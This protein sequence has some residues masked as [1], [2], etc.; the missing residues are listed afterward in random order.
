MKITIYKTIS[1]LGLLSFFVISCTEVIDI[2]LNSTNPEMNELLGYTLN[3]AFDPIPGLDMY[4]ALKIKKNG[5]YAAY[6]YGLALS[7]I[8]DEGNYVYESH[9]FYVMPGDTID[10][11]VYSIDFD[12]YTL[13][14]EVNDRLSGNMILSP[15]SY[16]A[17]SNLGED[18]MGYFMARSRIDTGFV[19]PTRL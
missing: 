5:F 1:L 4:Y 16:N 6:T 15:A 12:A 9:A 8:N 11:T 18:I 2:D 7:R 10:M 3:V 14:S 19:V 17:S 13:Y